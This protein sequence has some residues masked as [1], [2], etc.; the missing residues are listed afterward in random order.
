[1]D[2]VRLLDYQ[3][4]IVVININHPDCSREIF[5]QGEW[6]S[7]YRRHWETLGIGTM[8]RVCLTDNTL[9]TRILSNRIAEGTIIIEG[10]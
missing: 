8:Q 6:E 1:M 3:N 4:I 5:F 2:T 9:P 10:D 7:S